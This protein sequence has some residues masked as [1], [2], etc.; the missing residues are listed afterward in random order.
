MFAINSTNVNR[1]EHMRGGKYNMTEQMEFT[2]RFRK[3]VTERGGVTAVARLTGISRTTI[4]YWYQGT[5][6][7]DANNLLLLCDRLNVSCDFLL[8]RTEENNYTANEIVRKMTEYTG[9]SNK[10]IER[11]HVLYKEENRESEINKKT[12]TALGDQYSTSKIKGLAV[13]KGFNYLFNTNNEDILEKMS[14]LFE[15]IN[16]EGDES[17]EICGMYFSKHA[18]YFGGIINDIISQINELSVFGITG[19]E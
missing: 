12:F 7:P 13:V 2:K 18:L 5:R 10:T 1:T 14:Y 15:P 11:L 19:G 16:N 8:G 6:F 3:K 17:I 4:N 9:L